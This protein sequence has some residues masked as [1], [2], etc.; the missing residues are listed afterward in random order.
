MSEEPPAGNEVLGGVE[1]EQE[2]LSRLQDAEQS[3]PAGLPEVHFIDIGVG[4]QKAIP[5]VVRDRDVSFHLTR[6][7][8]QLVPL[9]QEVPIRPQ[10]ASLRNQNRRALKSL[11]A[12]SE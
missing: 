11:E 9:C 4:P 1:F 5:V 2:G 3:V 8:E 7:P 10:V 12:V 6:S